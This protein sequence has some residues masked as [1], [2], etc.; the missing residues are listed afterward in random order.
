MNTKGALLSIMLEMY[1]T[2]NY[3]PPIVTERVDFSTLKQSAKRSAKIARENSEKLIRTNDGASDIKAR[4]Q[5]AISSNP[6]EISH[7]EDT[8]ESFIREKGFGLAVDNLLIARTLSEC[9]KKQMKKFNTWEGQIL[10]DAYK[11]IRDSLVESAINI[12]NINEFIV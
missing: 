4:L 3:T 9:T 2:F 5:E 7:V 10:E 12:V 1:K 11:M 6:K 8:V